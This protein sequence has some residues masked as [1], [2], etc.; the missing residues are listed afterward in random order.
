M[1]T[2]IENLITLIVGLGIA[3]I[4]S[5]AVTLISLGILPLILL[6]SM[7][8]MSFKVGMQSN[9]DKMH[10]KNHELVVSSIMNIKTVRS[11]GLE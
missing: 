10:Q 6:S 8:M 7:L 11:C 9:T 2:I 3:F 4:F 5:W 1:P